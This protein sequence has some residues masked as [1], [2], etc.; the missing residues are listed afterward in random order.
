M[1]SGIVISQK[2]YNSLFDSWKN[3]PGPKKCTPVKWNLNIQ[4]IN[5]FDLSAFN[6]FKPLTHPI[7]IRNLTLIIPKALSEIVER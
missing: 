7:N 4:N 5:G 2:I 1:R 6:R 3:V